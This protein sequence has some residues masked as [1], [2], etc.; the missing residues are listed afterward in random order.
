MRGDYNIRERQKTRRDGGFEYIILAVFKNVVCLLLVHIEPDAH[1]F[2]LSYTFYKIGRAYQRAARGVNKDNAVLHPLYCVDIYHMIGLLG[3]RAMERYQIAFAEKF[4]EFDIS[5][6]VERG[7]PI[8]IIGDNIHPESAAG[9]RKRRAYLSRAYNSCRLSAEVDP[10]QS[11]EAEIVLAHFYISLVYAAIDGERERE[12]VL[13]YCLG[14]IPRHA[15]NGDAVLL[16]RRKIDI[17]IP[18]A[19]HENEPDPVLGEDIHDPPADIGRDEQ[20]H[21]V[22]AFRERRGAIRDIR[23]EIVYFNVGIFA[24]KLFERLAVIRLCIIKKYL[25]RMRLRQFSLNS[26]CRAGMNIRVK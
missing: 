13:G 15:H 24:C 9:A 1:K 18:G 5:N 16:R 8:L 2:M 22:I 10:G 6:E 17:V 3:Q 14:R 4:I 25:H 23:L 20:A 12:G 7:V 19:A 26:I 11:H 21:G